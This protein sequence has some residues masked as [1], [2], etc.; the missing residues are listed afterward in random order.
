MEKKTFEG[1]ADF[2]C[3]VKPTIPCNRINTYGM[4]KEF[5]F[6]ISYILCSIIS[7]AQ[8]HFSCIEPFTICKE[9]T[10]YADNIVRVLVQTMCFVTI[11]ILRSPTHTNNYVRNSTLKHSGD[12]IP[13][14][15]LLKDRAILTKHT[16]L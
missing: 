15:H 10:I 7:N 2:V 9:L 1:K 11:M 12:A 3:K 5:F 16:P 4:K 8:N 6:Y 14:S 13:C